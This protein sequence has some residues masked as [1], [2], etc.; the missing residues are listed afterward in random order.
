L[1]AD[2]DMDEAMANDLDALEALGNHD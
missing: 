2:K 1:T